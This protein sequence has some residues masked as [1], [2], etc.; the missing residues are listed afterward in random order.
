ML[1]KL[2]ESFAPKFTMSFSHNSTLCP[3]EETRF[4]LKIFGNDNSLWLFKSFLT[5]LLLLLIAS[6]LFSQ[7]GSDSLKNFD[8]LKLNS[9]KTDWNI[10]NSPLL[11][12]PLNMVQP[13]YSNNS[14]LYAFYTDSQINSGLSIVQPNIMLSQ[15]QL[16]NNWNTKKRYGV[17]AKYLGIAQFMG[18]IG[19]AAVSIANQSSIPK[20]KAKLKVSKKK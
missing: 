4:P 15:F 6:N 9:L 1:H 18:A 16:A 8:L 19:I 14:S 2:K 20:G 3:I 12:N 5:I 11:F 10:V 13:S 7:V 17:L